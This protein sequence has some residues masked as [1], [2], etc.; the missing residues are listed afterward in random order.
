MRP[1]GDV[2]LLTPGPTPIHPRALAAMQWPMR[3]H[4][5]PDVF[6]ANDAIVA[7]LKALYGAAPDAFAALLAGTG[8]LGMEAGIANLLEPGDRLVVGVNGV[9]GARMVEMAQRLGVEVHTVEAPLG[10]ALDVDEVVATVERLT[11]KC[12]PSCT[13]RPAP[14]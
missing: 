4:M 11:P 13:V 12:L 2:L 10:T 1:T 9:F 6:A 7:D 3:G 8:S 14:A 5:D